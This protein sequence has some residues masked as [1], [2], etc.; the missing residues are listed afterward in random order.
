[1]YVYQLLLRQCRHRYYWSILSRM[2]KRHA[3]QLV[4][5]ALVDKPASRRIAIE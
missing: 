2:K 4:A 5:T 1:V 3:L